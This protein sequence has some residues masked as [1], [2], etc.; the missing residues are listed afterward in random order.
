M[1]YPILKII[2][3]LSATLLIGFVVYDYFFARKSGLDSYPAKPVQV[4]V[5]Y[6]PGGGTDTFARIIQ[7]GIKDNNLM[8]QPLVIVNKPGGSTTIGSSY[9]KDA[10][11]DGYTMLCLHEAIITGYV[12]GQSP[13]G[14]DAFEPVGATGEI[15]QALVVSKDSPYRTFEE[16][17][18]EAIRHPETIKVGVTLSMPTHFSGLMLEDAAPGARFRFVSSTGGAARLGA[19]IGGH[20]DAS[21][22]SVSEYIRFK[23][24]GLR[25]LATFGDKRHPG[26]PE[27]PSALELGYDVSN[28]NLQYWWFPKGTDPTMI[29]YMRGVLE[30]AMETDYVRARLAEL[31]ILPQVIVGEELTDR[32]DSRMKR[33]S[34]MTLNQR[35]EL[36]NV[37]GWTLGGILIFGLGIV[38][39]YL[40]QGP[41]ESEEAGP[42]HLRF[43]LVKISLLFVFCYVLVMALG[44]MS[45]VWA[46]LIFVPAC[47]IL[48][49][50]FNN[51]RLVYVVE[52]SLLM[53]FGV[54]FV[55]TQLFLISLP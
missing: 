47:G 34:G 37:V 24:N 46:T 14:P 9:V 21:Y 12:T 40:R 6:D 32:I 27:V 39:S 51:T 35:V 38:R 13:H 10:R 18:E 49:T 26:I 8:P 19:L 28:S 54:Y 29:N 4:V 31:S 50:G 36:P 33:F 22:F 11:N 7:K 45:Y 25:P 43:D 16:F 30:K 17:M 41:K 1:Q 23:E 48:L 53:S 2:W 52:I 3:H 42:I 5:P 55:F 15:I 20:V 44:F